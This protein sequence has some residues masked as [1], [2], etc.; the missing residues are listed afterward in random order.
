MEGGVGGGGEWGGGGYSNCSP[1]IP[2]TQ[3]QSGR[4]Q[5]D[6]GQFG[7]NLLLNVMDTYF[8]HYSQEQTL[9]G[10]TEKGPFSGTLATYYNSLEIYQKLTV[11]FNIP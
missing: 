1:G 7:K 4:V 10:F 9:S 3:T 2:S 11:L 5:H 6:I 8:A